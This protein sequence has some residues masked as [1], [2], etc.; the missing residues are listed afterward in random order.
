MG[1]VIDICN[2]VEQ[3]E[4]SVVA[5]FNLKKTLYIGAA[6][7]SGA[8][9]MAIFI[10]VFHI[11]IVIS[12]YLMMPFVAPIILKGFYREGKGSFIK[13]LLNMRR[14]SKP[15]VYCSTEMVQAVSIQQEKK[16]STHGKKKVLRTRKIT[17]NGK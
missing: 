6:V 1:L 7:L 3:Y 12:A 2:D 17:S 5:G 14:K 16:D 11:N 4:E 13:D 9:C 15:L 10:F 8:V